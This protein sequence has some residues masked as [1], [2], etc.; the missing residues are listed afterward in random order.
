MK[1]PFNYKK[2]SVYIEEIGSVVGKSGKSFKDFLAVYL[3][4]HCQHTFP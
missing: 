4:H 1:I 2:T 3:P